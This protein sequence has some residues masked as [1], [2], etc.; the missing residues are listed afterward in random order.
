MGA[1]DYMDVS[2][3]KVEELWKSY[4]RSRGLSSELDPIPAGETA[5][6]FRRKAMLITLDSENQSAPIRLIA[7]ELNQNWI[8]AASGFA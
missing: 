6:Q 1:F 4:L 2:T 3:A 5:E 8:K 7:R